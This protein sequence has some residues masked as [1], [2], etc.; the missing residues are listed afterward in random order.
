MALT[1]VYKPYDFHHISVEWIEATRMEVCSEPDFF[2]YVPGEIFSQ[3][4]AYLELS[5]LSS[6]LGVSKAAY[7]MTRGL[8]E[9]VHINCTRSGETFRKILSQFSNIRDLSIEFP[10]DLGCLEMMT[11]SRLA[12][13]R[14][15]RVSD[16]TLMREPQALFQALWS[17]TQLV[18]LDLNFLLPL[19]A[20]ATQDNFAIMC[21]LGTLTK[22]EYLRIQ[23]AP[24]SWNAVQRSVFLSLK[25]LKSLEI[26]YTTPPEDLSFLQPLQNLSMLRLH[27]IGASQTGLQYELPCLPKLEQLISSDICLDGLSISRVPNLRLLQFTPWG[28]KRRDLMIFA[29]MRQLEHLSLRVNWLP[30]ASFLEKIFCHLTSLTLIEF[31][32]SRCNALYS[33][34]NLKILA[35]DSPITSKGE[36]IKAR[37]LNPITELLKAMTWLVGFSLINVT[38]VTYDVMQ[39]I[40]SPSSKIKLLEL[41]G[42]SS[43]MEAFTE[44]HAKDCTQKLA[45]LTLHAE[46]F[47]YKWK[48]GQE[49]FSVRATAEEDFFHESFP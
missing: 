8:T 43:C 49:R 42:C 6:L 38:H 32:V 46:G 44:L 26:S 4:L 31:D 7:Q 29:E 30:N 37:H 33:L 23:Y 19:R 1:S 17:C 18:A 41:A 25:N 15:L 39:A 2:S 3:F 48:T 36:P 20:P 28:W 40:L 27:V 35:L 16:V 5:D 9:S 10:N 14:T 22:L 11:M 13:L 45:E 12:H 34:K 47:V 21:T 24:E